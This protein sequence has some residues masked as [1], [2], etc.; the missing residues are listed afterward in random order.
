MLDKKNILVE[1]D[2]TPNNIVKNSAIL[3]DASKTLNKEVYSEI[4][5]VIEAIRNLFNVS[6]DSAY[7]ITFLIESNPKIAEQLIKIYDSMYTGFY[8]KDGKWSI[9]SLLQYL[10]KIIKTPN[11]YTTKI[12]NLFEIP[13]LDTMTTVS[14]G[15]SSNTQY[16]QLLDSIKNS[17]STLEN[18]VKN[19]VSD[20]KNVHDPILDKHVPE[21]GKLLTNILSINKISDSI[22]LK[23]AKYQYSKNALK[24]VETANAEGKVASVE[25]IKWVS[26]D[27]SSLF[28]ETISKKEG[29]TYVEIIPD[30]VNEENEKTEVKVTYKEWIPLY[31]SDISYLKGKENYENII[32]ILANYLSKSNT[33]TNDIDSNVDYIN[34]KIKSISATDDAVVFRNNLY[35]DIQKMW[36]D[37]GSTV[38]DAYHTILNTFIR[39]GVKPKNYSDKLNINQGVTP[40]PSLGSIARK[41]GS[42]RE[43]DV[44]KYHVLLSDAGRMGENQNGIVNSANN[45]FIDFTISGQKYHIESDDSTML[46]SIYSP[47]VII[48]G[49]TT[50][51]GPLVGVGYGIVFYKN[52]ISGKSSDN[53]ELTEEDRKAL[54]KEKNKESITSDKDSIKEYSTKLNDL[55]NAKKDVITA[56]YPDETPELIDKTIS[57][58]DTNIPEFVN[59]YENIVKER[60]SIS[61]TNENIVKIPVNTLI[62][63]LFET[64]DISKS[65]KYYVSLTDIMSARK[66]AYKYNKDDTEKYNNMDVDR[67]IDSIT[68]DPNITPE[69]KQQ[70]L[71][72]IN[73]IHNALFDNNGLYNN[74]IN[75]CTKSTDVF[76]NKILKFFDI[77]TL[78]TY[79]NIQKNI[80]VISKN[81]EEYENADIIEKKK[82]YI[83]KVNDLNFKK[84]E[85]LK[86]TFPNVEYNE[87]STISKHLDKN[88][89][90]IVN[91][92]NSFIENRNVVADKNDNI[93]A[94][95]MDSVFKR[96]FQT[97]DAENIDNI[98]STYIDQLYLMSIRKIAYKNN[99]DAIKSKLYKNM[100]VDEILQN[101]KQNTNISDTEKN[102]KINEI[103]AVLPELNQLKN[104]FVGLYNDNKNIFN[105]KYIKEFSLKSLF[106]YANLN[107]NQSTLDEY[108]KEN[109]GDIT[110][111]DIQQIKKISDNKSSVDVLLEK[112]KPNKEMD[113]V[114]IDNVDDIENNTTDVDFVQQIEDVEKILDSIYAGNKKAYE[115]LQG[116]DSTPAKVLKTILHNKN[117]KKDDI[118]YVKQLLY[119]ALDK[120]NPEIYGTVRGYGK[121][122]VLSRLDEKN[123]ISNITGAISDVYNA[124]DEADLNQVI[125]RLRYVIYTYENFKNKTF[126]EQGKKLLDEIDEIK[127]LPFDEKINKIKS[128][129]SDYSN[130][131]LDYNVQTYKTYMDSMKNVDVSY[132]NENKESIVNYIKGRYLSKNDQ[133]YPDKEN[134]QHSLGT[135]NKENLVNAL[136][137][138]ETLRAKLANEMISHY[139]DP[140]NKKNDF[141]ELS[142]AEMLYKTKNMTNTV[143]RNLGVTGQQSGD[144]KSYI[145]AFDTNALKNLFINLISDKNNALKI[146][147]TEYNNALNIDSKENTS[148][149]KQQFFAKYKL[150][151][152]TSMSSN[153][154]LDYIIEKVYKLKNGSSNDIL[155]EFLLKDNEAQY[156]AAIQSMKTFIK[157]DDN[158]DSDENELSENNKYVSSLKNDVNTAIQKRNELLKLKES[159]NLTQKNKIELSKASAFIDKYAQKNV[160]QWNKLSSVNTMANKLFDI[161]SE[162]GYDDDEYI[163]KIIAD[164]KKRGTLKN[165]PKHDNNYLYRN[166][167]FKPN[168]LFSIISKNLKKEFELIH[169]EYLVYFN[170]ILPKLLTDGDGVLSQGE[171]VKS[172]AFTYKD[173]ED[174]IIPF[175]IDNIPDDIFEILKNDNIIDSDFN[176][177]SKNG[178]INKSDAEYNNTLQSILNKYTKN[179]T[180]DDGTIKNKILGKEECYKYM[181]KIYPTTKQG[182]NLLAD[183]LYTRIMNN[184][185]KNVKSDTKNTKYNN[186]MYDFKHD[187]EDEIKEKLLLRLGND[188]MNA[189]G[190]KNIT[191]SEERRKISNEKIKS[192]TLPKNY[193]VNEDDLVKYYE[194][195]LRDQEGG[196]AYNR[197]LINE[198]I[199][200]FG[201]DRVLDAL[202]K[203][204]TN[205]GLNDIY[206][207][208]GTIK[209]TDTIDWNNIN[210]DT[211]SEYYANILISGK[212]MPKK[213]YDKLI[214]SL[215]EDKMLS[216][217]HKAE[218]KLELDDIYDITGKKQAETK[219]PISNVTKTEDSDS[220]VVEKEVPIHNEK[221]EEVLESVLGNN[222]FKNADFYTS[223]IE[224]IKSND[225]LTY[226][227]ID[228]IIN[229]LGIKQLI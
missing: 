88:I 111:D 202:K 46:N 165:D 178:K 43:E 190:D 28:N 96:F 53:V 10:E 31:M 207:I 64:N 219:K 5:D 226:S 184:N 1:G 160:E 71:E 103:N 91:I 195:I 80:D 79:A 78:L 90:T 83:E 59:T 188:M 182:K 124:K 17:L 82:D 72:D 179:Q 81:K 104:T 58:L 95:P 137:N 4:D 7:I 169:S 174:N 27:D 125:G 127:T 133:N 19:K 52:F 41:T 87:L 13:F 49:S 63:K 157:A 18:D 85:I 42:T 110:N 44:G 29:D 93:I 36:I 222:I 107:K 151:N 128:L 75:I 215:G 183:A 166:I 77:N 193:V 204:E 24:Y 101:I 138:N 74:L 175:T 177:I 39:T 92:Y 98:I 201:K 6:T 50:D 130:K 65:V 186:F 148:K 161:E 149:N 106:S 143:D 197:S 176:I 211:L 167:T 67:I 69:L 171:L 205:L 213:L 158:D 14:G 25:L 56:L 228:N 212:T 84:I 200:K 105:D 37:N 209:R 118:S 12:S 198:F 224:S 214:N 23:T 21:K 154:M 139:S 2:Y 189:T 89:N 51:V 229:I 9:H 134:E 155:T 99:D 208:D 196:S 216:S 100:G 34:D 32:S 57:K 62:E 73:T 142:P 194:T 3:V 61:K 156:V 86:E 181:G 94:V 146:L 38:G 113:T 117:I 109:I 55:S 185:S 170:D 227:D 140:E 15:S 20:I 66:I 54:E 132:N 162:H 16:T 168:E 131:Y 221:P 126:F 26:S 70:K 48:R 180:L 141:S 203:A 112:N 136:K 123:V 40:I 192:G 191:D 115:D 163:N 172:S 187:T 173:S 153:E 76:S 116:M 45:N 164:M 225:S 210:T 119:K 147:N 150:P 129:C 223:L 68:R 206:T 120:I 97:N 8:D 121:E 218:E 114:D 22:Y 199:I 152:N 217:L 135:T 122:N 159:G 144:G 33:Q 145:T 102:E 35:T 11:I 47:N 60:D 30:L 108:A 220:K